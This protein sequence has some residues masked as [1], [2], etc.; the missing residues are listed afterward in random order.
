MVA[1]L[2]RAGLDFIIDR[3]DVG[4]LVVTRDFEVVLWNRFMAAHSGVSHEHIVGG[5]LFE[6]FP[7]L[8]REWLAKK[9]KSVFILNNF[10]FSS[11]QQRPYLFRFKHHRPI[12]GGAS[13]MYQDCTF[14]PFKNQEGD[15]DLVCITVFDV[16][17]VAIAQKQLSEARERM[18]ELSNQDAL[19][20]VYNRRYLQVQLTREFNRVVRNGGALSV[21][22]IDL[23]YF[24]NVNDTYGHPAGDYVLVEVAQRIKEAVRTTDYL[25]RYGGEEFAVVLSDTGMNGGINVANRIRERIAEAPFIFEGQTIA[26]TASLGLSEYRETVETPESLLAESDEALYSA[27]QSGR[28]RV[29]CYKA[30]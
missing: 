29:V 5:S 10:A 4:I 18:E 23:D 25:A 22:F 15:Q 8:P 30:S 19:T 13:F 21:L 20:G 9:L 14:V 26:M 3:V 28:N 1:E 11:W 7:E 24:K 12:T 17:D 6:S 16:T 27:K 2:Q